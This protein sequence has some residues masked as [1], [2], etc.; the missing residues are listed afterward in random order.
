MDAV[1]QGDLT[2][3]F[4][5]SGTHTITAKYSGDPSYAASTSSVATLQVLWQTTL[6]VTPASSSVDLRSKRPSHSNSH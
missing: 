5:N 3:T 1:A 2:I 4:P 6:T